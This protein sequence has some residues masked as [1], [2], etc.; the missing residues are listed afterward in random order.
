MSTITSNLGLFKYD[1]PG[2]N[3]IA[4]NIT[5][6]LNQNWDRLDAGVAL[7][8]H[9]HS[10]Y[11]ST[12]VSG[13]NIKTINGN[14]LLGSGNITIESGGS[15][16]T[17]PTASKTTLGGV[18][19]DG[20]TITISNGVISSSGSSSYEA[21]KALSSN[22]YM[23]FSNG[24]TIAWCRH[25]SSSNGSNTFSFPCTFTSLYQVATANIGPNV[26]NSSTIVTYATTS[27]AKAVIIKSI[28]T[29]SVTLLYTT[30]NCGN[31]FIL[32][33]KI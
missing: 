13:T 26:V 10:G 23:K 27:N 9:I 7:K 16:Y 19:I 32:I 30:T 3:N 33:G 4:F 21:A 1:L 14:S 8:N 29:S 17:L 11:Q 12:L 6:A 31:C 20:T 22:G 15:S 18:K 24:F 25:T 2:D 28:S 5:N